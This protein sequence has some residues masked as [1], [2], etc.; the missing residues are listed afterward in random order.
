ML[1]LDKV[2]VSAGKKTIVKEV[3]FTVKPGE[4][5]VLM[6]PNG[7]GKSSLSLALAGHPNYQLKGKV[8]LNGKVINKLQPEERAKLGLFLGLQDPVSVPGLSIIPFIWEAFRQ[9]KDKDKTSFGEFRKKAEKLAQKLGIKY[10]ILQRGVNEN[11]S[12]GEKKKLEIL[13]LLMLRPKY[14]ILDEPDSGLD[15]DALKIIA[16]QIKNLAAEE[17][18]G[19]LVIT[20]Y[21]RILRWLKPNRILVMREGKIVTQGSIQLAEEI[22]KK[23]Y[24]FINGSQIKK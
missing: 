18:T 14:A 8:S 9:I 3:S 16:S 6:G 20:H 10:S 2:F 1:K 24:K 5:V 23:G 11:L 21:Q 15:I 17:K 12:G 7:S 22:E 13:Q 4:I 19:C